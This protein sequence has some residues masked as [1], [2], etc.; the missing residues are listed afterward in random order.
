ML[1]LRSAREKQGKPT[2]FVAGNQ[3]LVSY[4]YACRTAALAQSF[5][6]KPMDTSI[7]KSTQFPLYLHL[8]INVTFAKL[9]HIHS[10]QFV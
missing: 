7:V 9:A 8:K 3:L 6:L 4:R 1:K 2:I 10:F 5:S